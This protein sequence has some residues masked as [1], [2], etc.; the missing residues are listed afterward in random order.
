MTTGALSQCGTCVRLRGP[1]DDGAPLGLDGPWCEAF[2]DGIPG[3][4]LGPIFTNQVDHRQPQPGDHGLRWSPLPGATFPQLYPP[5]QTASLTAAAAGEPPTGAMIALVPSADDADYLSVDGGEPAE[6]MHCTL[7]YLGEAGDV[8]RETQTAIVE[9]LRGLVED[10]LRGEYELPIVADGF[11]VSMFNPDTTDACVVLGLS[12]EDLDIIHSMIVDAVAEA[13]AD[14]SGQHRPWVPHITLIYTSDAGQ[15]EDLVDRVGPIVLDR[16]RVAFAD[17]IEDIP[18]ASLPVADDEPAVEQ[19]PE[20]GEQAGPPDTVSAAA[21]QEE[22]PMM[23]DGEC[24]PGQHLMPDGTCMPDE[25]MPVETPPAYAL[26]TGTPWHAIAAVEGQWSGDGRQF[27]PGALD[28]AGMFPQPLKWQ[29][30][31]QPGHDG[32]VT[33]GRVDGAMRQGPLIWAWGVFDDAG[34]QGGEALRLAQGEFIRGVSI[35][36][37]DVEPHDV[38]L[39]CPAPA[40]VPELDETPMGLEDLPEDMP[41]ELYGGP[42]CEAPKEIVHRARMRSLT[43]V[44]EAAFPECVLHLGPPPPELGLTLIAAAVG[45]HETATS[46]G[47]WDGPGNEKKLPS[48]MPAATGRKAYAWIDE[49]QIADGQM[50]KTAGRFIHHEI[51]ADGA[52][53]AANLT[54]CSTG[55]GVLNG[56][57]GGTTVPAGDVQ[58]IYNH[59]A[60]HL[61]DGDREPPLLTAAARTIVAAGYTITIPE[62]WPEAWFDPPVEAPPIGALHVTEQG[63]V[64]GYLAPGGVGHRA[65]RASGRR[66]EAPRRIDYSEFMNKPALV[67]DGDGQVHRINAG[68]ITFGCGHM[69]P[70]DPRRADPNAALEHYDNSCSVAARIRVGEDE[71]GTWV[72]GGLLHSLDGDTVERMMGCALSGDWQEGRLNAALLVPVEGFPTSVAGNVRIRDGAVVASTAPVLF[73]E[74]A[75]PPTGLGPIGALDYIARTVG[76]DSNS[77]MSELAQAFDH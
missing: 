9:R 54:A 1:F 59:L 19:P 55:I 13:G 72:A 3:G 35:K 57:R 25:E 53:G 62:V 31:E 8:L 11:A 6:Q 73:D 61:R 40:A 39:V 27:A 37:D 23:P 18:L 21:Q 68:N 16:L 56:G 32:S 71:H 44:G 76:W 66:I 60:G 43:L 38:E 74:P 5:E 2:P 65:F 12:G 29:P 17:R 67:A 33:V 24:P 58:G 52:P 46:D 34:E 28:W 64:Y 47:T 36:A 75:A 42:V 10:Q 49:A 7:L 77:R 22:A 30:T 45:A 63:R 20:A 14:T 48:P 50:P 41:D 70:V 26:G 15:V 4:V 51:G 69:S